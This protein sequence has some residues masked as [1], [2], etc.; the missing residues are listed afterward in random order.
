MILIFYLKKIMKKIA[1]LISI[2]FLLS[3]CFWWEVVEKKINKKTEFLL[4]IKNSDDL[5]KKY[6]LEKSSKIEASTSIDVLSEISA[7]VEKISVKEWE[8]VIAW[9][10]LV[11]FYDN[12]W[13]INTNYKQAVLN[14]EQAKISY[15]S[16]KISLDKNIFDL[17]NDLEKLKNNYENQKKIIDQDIISSKNSLEN[18]D[19]SKNDSKSNL[20]LQKLDNFIEKQLFDL[21]TQKKSNQDKID[22]FVLNLQREKDTLNNL[23]TNTIELWDDI[24]SIKNPN[25][26][27]EKYLFIWAWNS[28]KKAEAER[29]LKKMIDFQ[30]KT[31]KNLNLE[32]KDEIEKYSKKI[33]EAYNLLKNF[34]DN[35][36]ETLNSSLAWLTWYTES[37]KNI[38]LTK[39]NNYIWTYSWNYANYISLKSQI[40]SF[41]NTYK[42]WENSILKQIELSKKDREITIKSLNNSQITTKSAY[43][44][45]II[46]SNDSISNMQFQIKSLE[47]N[48]LNT[49]KTREI[50]LKNLENSIKNAE[51]ALEKASIEAWKL[52]LK[53]PISWQI[54]KINVTE[55][56]NYWPSSKILTLISSSKRELDVFV[57]SEDLWKI[58][59]KD[60]VK[61]D[62][63]WEKFEWEI[64]S[65]SNVADENLNYKVKVSL[66]KEINLVW[67]VANVGFILKTEFPLLPVN[68]VTVLNSENDKKIGEINI[69]K[70]AK[71]E[72]MEVELGEVFWKNIEIK[73]K[74]PENLQIILNDVVNFDEDKFELKVK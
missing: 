74:I 39:V 41:L 16:Q 24:F 36:L 68:S 44:K 14:L 11:Y 63:R 51:L 7:R 28:Q 54:S 6:F 22:A 8:N 1:V 58:N 66:D 26:N 17:E 35:T 52:V 55:W 65:K 4:D 67:W 56:Q 30:E 72:K 38:H 18:L 9:Q 29:Y 3:S 2:I 46:S 5:E 27:S 42:D 12:S 57:N 48:L 61:I 13:N 60:K 20:D 25:Y 62:Y 23:Y 40:S 71:I 33:D 70:N 64:F 73:T 49:K 34:L 15:E 10:P 37:E 69:L 59:V 21:E 47:N 45:L 32:S 53:A 31:L 43:D 50:N 19:I